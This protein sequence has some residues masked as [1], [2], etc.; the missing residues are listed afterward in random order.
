MKG[1]DFGYPEGH[2][3]YDAEVISLYT[4]EQAV[5]DGIKF[6]LGERLWCTTNFART[7]A[8]KWFVKKHREIVAGP[9][10]SDAQAMHAVHRL[11]P[12]SLE[13]ATKHDGYSIERDIDRGT[14]R[15]IVSSIVSE[16]VGG[17]YAVP[18]R[19]DEYGEA[20][21]GLASYLVEPETGLV[22]QSAAPS[23]QEV[24]VWAVG[25]HEGLHI[26]LPEDY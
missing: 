5:A 6:Q 3:F 19:A 16:Y 24:K 1:K 20:D 11:Q 18:K 8:N 4:S 14:L 21:A 15:R 13:W 2:P 22:D 7:V 25:D 26:I 10:D 12:Q 9:F 23:Q 17:A